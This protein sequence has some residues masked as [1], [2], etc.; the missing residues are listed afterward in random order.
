MY[1]CQYIWLV[2]RSQ[3]RYKIGMRARRTSLTSCELNARVVAAYI[4]M[5]NFLTCDVAGGVAF[6]T[7]V[8]RVIFACYMFV[9]TTPILAY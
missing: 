5:I 3:S 1:L 6:T 2:Q 4:S 7:S 9:G 8:G